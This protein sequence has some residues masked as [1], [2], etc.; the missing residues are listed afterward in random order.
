MLVLKVDR[1]KCLLGIARFRPFL[2]YSGRN[3]VSSPDTVSLDPKTA[4]AAARFAVAGERELQKRPPRSEMW[5]SDDDV[6]NLGKKSQ[7]NT[8]I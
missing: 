6:D 3:A 4:A 8:T 1:C 7:G 5:T 2:H